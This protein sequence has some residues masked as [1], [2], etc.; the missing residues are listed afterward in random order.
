[1]PPLTR[2]SSHSI[3]QTHSWLSSDNSLYIFFDSSLL[4]VPSL[5]GSY[6]KLSCGA[7]Y[8]VFTYIYSLLIEKDLFECENI[9]VKFPCVYLCFSSRDFFIFSVRV[10]PF[11]KF[12][13]YFFM[14]TDHD[15][16]PN[17]TIQSHV[18]TAVLKNQ[19]HELDMGQLMFTAIKNHITRRVR[20]VQGLQKD[21]RALI[22]AI[23][24][25]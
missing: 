24:P 3:L 21:D 22:Q 8:C 18:I 17:L 13:F 16:D 20:R 5:G 12:M 25:N 9:S 19:V 4:P 14:S 10:S 1:M 11:L 23:A 6:L 2:L 15:Q 7:F